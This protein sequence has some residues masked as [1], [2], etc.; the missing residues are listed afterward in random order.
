ML[1]L[2]NKNQKE[3]ILDEYYSRLINIF[4]T[5]LIILSLIFLILLFP[6]YLNMNVDKK[7]LINKAGLLKK[8]IDLYKVKNKKDQTFGLSDDVSILSTPTNDTALIIF[9]EVKSIYKEIPNIRLISINVDVLN[10]KVIVSAI[11]DNKN[12]ASLLVDR[13]NISK[14]KGADLPYS[15]FSQNKSFTFNQSLSYE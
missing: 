10:K 13:L 9:E 11:V 3:K 15:V 14:Y 6:V 8:E 12:T 1:Y 4:T 5:S 7:I 2:I